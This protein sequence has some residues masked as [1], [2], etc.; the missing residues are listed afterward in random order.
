MDNC[1]VS[2]QRLLRE[3]V[4]DGRLAHHVEFPEVVNGHCFRLK[5]LTPIET[6][7]VD[8]EQLSVTAISV[9]FVPDERV[10]NDL[11]YPDV[12]ETA[13]I[14]GQSLVYSRRLRHD[15][16]CRY[17]TANELVDMIVWMAEGHAD[18]VEILDHVYQVDPVYDQEVLTDQ[19]EDDDEDDLDDD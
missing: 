12:I 11:D 5:F 4:D 2:A 17:D 14:S 7:S 3:L 13:L 8:G 16:V 9:S 18:L 10:Q 6:V 15:D 19:E 1:K